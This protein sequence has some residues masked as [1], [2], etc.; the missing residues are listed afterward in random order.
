MFKKEKVAPSNNNQ[1]SGEMDVHLN[2]SDTSALRLA[3]P[4]SIP[5]LRPAHKYNVLDPPEKTQSQQST[6]CSDE[7]NSPTELNS[8]KKISDKP[9]LIKR[10]AMG[11]TGVANMS[12]DDSCPLVTTSS[13]NSTPN[14]PTRATPGSYVNEAEND[15]TQN[16]YVKHMYAYFIYCRKWI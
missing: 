6:P 3:P 14:S 13:P 12:D 4:S 2:N 10:I 11:L 15:N 1:Q 5:G 16:R 7:S 8:C 9:P